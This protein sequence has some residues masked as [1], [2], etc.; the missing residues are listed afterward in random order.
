MPPKPRDATGP[1]QALIYRIDYLQDLLKHLPSSLPLDPPESLYQFYLDEDWAADAGTVFPVAGRALELSFDTWKKDSMV[2]FTE[3][4]S[5]V[6]A[7]GP[8]LK[9]VLKRMMAGE[10]VAFETA[11]IDS[12]WKLLL[13]FFKMSVKLN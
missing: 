9:S 5:R 3:R 4:G 12:C 10:R 2:K 13:G 1:P 8:F 6:A 11:W 7:L